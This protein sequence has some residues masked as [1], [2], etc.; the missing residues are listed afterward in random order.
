MIGGGFSAESAKTAVDETYEDYKLAVI[1]GRHWTS[2]L[3]LPF[4]VKANV[5][6]VKYDRPTF[7]VPGKP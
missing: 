3:D 1:F 7:Y 5:P 6:F 2:N 4:R